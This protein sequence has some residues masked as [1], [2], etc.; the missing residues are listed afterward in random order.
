MDGCSAARWLTAKRKRARRD[1]RQRGQN[2]R[3]PHH[4][5]RCNGKEAIMAIEWLG[6]RRSN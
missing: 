1:R 4:A 3:E 5:V 2:K 6:A